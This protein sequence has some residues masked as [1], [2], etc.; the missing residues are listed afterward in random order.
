MLITVVS[1]FSGMASAH[2]GHGTEYPEEIPIEVTDDTSDSDSGSSTTNSGNDK[3][4]TSN[5]KSKTTT[6]NSKSGSTLSSSSNSLSS[7]NPTE[8]SLNNAED[9]VTPVA[10][11]VTSNGSDNSTPK[12]SSS[13]LG[14]PVIGAALMV[15]I[16]VIA[17]GGHYS[18]Q[19]SV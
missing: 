9:S 13:G 12:S 6:S 10:D 17:G 8:G 11:E 14:F 4:K 1:A 7:S 2:P 18:A 5:D 19:I 3:S 16:G 15:A